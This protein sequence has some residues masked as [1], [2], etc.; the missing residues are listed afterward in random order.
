MLMLSD[1]QARIVMW[2]NSRLIVLRMSASANTMRRPLNRLARV[3]DQMVTV[4]NG[5]D[6]YR[7]EVPETRETESLHRG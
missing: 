3:L 1:P 4:S 6:E 2:N 5:R 7:Q